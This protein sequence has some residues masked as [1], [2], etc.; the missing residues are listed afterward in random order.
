MCHNTV[1]YFNTISHSG[2]WGVSVMIIR[3]WQS[4]CFERLY[5]RY[6]K[7]KEILHILFWEN[8]DVNC[9]C[10]RLSVGVNFTNYFQ[11]GEM[12]WKTKLRSLFSS[13]DVDYPIRTMNEISESHR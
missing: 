11:F 1:T 3:I 2:S 12:L 13:M 10:L 6:T 5:V 4:S 7:N 8:D 9:K